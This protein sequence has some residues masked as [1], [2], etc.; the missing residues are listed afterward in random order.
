MGTGSDYSA[1]YRRNPLGKRNIFGHFA[2]VLG[3]VSVLL[4]FVSGVAICVFPATFCFT[5]EGTKSYAVW[6]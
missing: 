6:R 5:A 3:R 4:P 1:I 2:L